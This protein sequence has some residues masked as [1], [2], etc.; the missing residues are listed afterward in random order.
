MYAATVRARPLTFQVSGMLW[1]RS[2]VMRDKETG[3]LWSHILGE[4]MRGDLKGEKLKLIPSV[5]TDW[6][7]WKAD[8]PETTVLALDR[9]ARQF[10]TE[11]Q[12]RPDTF[13]L[14]LAV[15]GKTK[16]Y[17]FDILKNHP[18]LNDT[19][20]DLPVLITFDRKSTGA[21]MFNRALGDQ[22]LTFLAGKEGA[23]SDKETNSTWNPATGRCTKGKLKGKELTPI[24]AI[25]SFRKA[26][27]TFHPDSEVYKA[28][29]S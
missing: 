14:G 10:R 26:W 15:R 13:V 27:N 8:H 23:L 22:T 25:I 3:S 24:P 1:N 2:L 29:R 16:A 9:T 11:F 17:A 28:P 6:R 12:Q 7:S 20:A 18:V 21:R 4:S 19:F 5:I